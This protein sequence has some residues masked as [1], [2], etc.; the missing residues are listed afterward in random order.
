MLAGSRSNSAGATS[1]LITSPGPGEGK[2]TSAISLATSLALTHK[3][4]ILIEGDLRRP[5]IGKA[6]GMS[7]DVGVTSVL[8]GD[9]TLEE[10]LVTARIG[11]EYLALL[12]AEEAGGGGAELLALPTAQLLVEEAKKIADVVVDRLAAARHG[13]RRAAARPHRRRGRARR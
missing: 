3:R 13:H 7:V 2:T 12:L 1:I 9:A 5:T 6:F 10:S 4:V 11:D 8:T